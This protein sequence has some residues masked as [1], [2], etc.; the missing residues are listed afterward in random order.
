MR[1]PFSRDRFRRPERFFDEFLRK[2]VKGLFV[3]RGENVPV[4]YR[5]LVVGVDT[6]GGKLENP[7]GSGKVPHKIDDK[8][9]D[10]PA[11]VG[12]ENPPNSIK[13]RV[14]TDGLDRFYLDD[15]LRV[16]WPFFP[17]T[18]AIPVKPGEHV[19]VMFEDSQRTHGLWISKVSGHTGVNYAP[20]DKFYE[21]SDSGNLVGLF[22]DSS[23]AQGS[24]Q[25][26]VN[27]DSDAGETKS[28]DKLSSLFGN[29]AR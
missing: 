19:Y 17:D 12:P 3:E 7:D 24:Q 20:G 25:T 22:P 23:S 21:D 29:N 6:E 27:T 15:D 5:A 14:L 9:F 16:F 11:R 10:A 28:G 26:D 13:A 18:H 1:E 8:K 2:G 4:I